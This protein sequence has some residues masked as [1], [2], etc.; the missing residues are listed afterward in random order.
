MSSFQDLTVTD[1]DWVDLYGALSV[2]LTSTLQFTVKGSAPI[3]YFEAVSKPLAT[4]K[5]GIVISYAD[6]RV[7]VLPKSGEKV[8]VKCSDASG[9][10]IDSTTI[11]ALLG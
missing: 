2:A 4:S 9:Q 10:S 6:G 11:S 1:A 3:L 5:D 8:W 7:T